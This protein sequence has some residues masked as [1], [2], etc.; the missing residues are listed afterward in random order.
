MKPWQNLL[1]GILIGLLAAALILLVATRPRG[2]PITLSSPPTP[3]LLTVHVTGAVVQPGVYDLA[4]GSRVN[5]AIQ[6]ARGL[7]ENAD[8]TYLNLAAI[9]RDGDR[10]WVPLQVTP[11]PS[12]QPGETLQSTAKPVRTTPVPPSADH[13]LDINTATQAQLDQLPGIGEIKAEAIISYRNTHG[14]FL[15]V[16]DLLNVP[17]ITPAILENIKDVITVLPQP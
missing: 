12:P 10:V 15:D 5:D 7:K 13:P 2:S 14:P 16:Q 3:S 17:G 8:V 6:A 11:T 4:P 1:A 9:L